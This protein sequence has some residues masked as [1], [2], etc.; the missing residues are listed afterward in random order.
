M[1]Y[2][3][4][5]VIAIAILLQCNLS[6]GQAPDID[7][8]KQ[9]VAQGVPDTNTVI[10]C[11][12][13]CGTLGVSEPRTALK[14]GR[15]GVALSKQIKWDKGTAGCYLNIGGVYMNIG[16]YD[17]AIMYLDTALVYSKK[18]GEDKR[19]ALVYINIAATYIYEEKLEEAMKAA[20][21]AMPYAEASKDPDRIARVN[22]TLGNILYY[23]ERWNDALPY[24]KKCLSIFESLNNP[25][26]I[27]TSYMNLGIIMKNTNKLDSAQLY[28]E[29]ARDILIEL[30]DTEKLIP[31]YYNLGGI[32]QVKKDY[33]GA[34]EQFQKAV[35]LS[36]SFGDKEQEVYNKHSL[37]E[38]YLLTK[39]YA[40]AEQIM[41]PALDTAELYKFYEEISY[42]TETLSDLYAERG[43]FKKSLE[44]LQRFNV[45][46][47]TLDK[48][49]ANSELLKLQEAFNAENRE[50][51]I[52]LLNTE[53]ALKDEQI[54][55]NRLLIGILI[56]S[57][58]VII[59]TGGFFWN[60]NRLNQQLKEV[61][62]RNKIASDL[63]DDVG[64][65]LSSIN[66]YSEI[67]RRDVP[68]SGTNAELFLTKISENAKESIE[69]MSDIVWMVKP[70]ADKLGDL[71]SRMQTYATDMC[72]SAGMQL[73]AELPSDQGA[74]SLPMD[75]RR[76]IYL[77]FKEAVNNAAKYS[78]ATQLNVHL[79]LVSGVVQLMI[80]DNGKGFPSDQQKG[81]GLD[82]MR[83]R[84]S[85][86]RGTCT[87]DSGAQG[88]TIST[89]IPLT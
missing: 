54:L 28:T 23:Q 84:A 62:L 19:T 69:Q 27:A 49:M 13:L 21:Q 4:L 48:R 9:V 55:K 86:H 7:S 76:D 66:M 68:V 17:T 70:G 34:E 73:E 42:L 59:I 71:F 31:L 46:K 53:A 56:A 6:F 75:I 1:K 50:K 16:I 61:R 32:L 45:A 30:D 52:A 57:V 58:L 78:G 60:R 87:I 8:L 33:T 35:D 38:I 80:A 3:R 89:M 63:H 26:M 82:N 20:L 14:Y 15:K 83:L 65:T 43:E 67:I 29:K 77:I 18:V 64:A 39:Q 74:I 47:D 36:I 12:A 44:Y 51:E 79:K 22:L 24:Y 10:A 72:R 85:R 25:G 37:G 88:T 41:L 11:R 40:K 81:N 5:Y 2:N